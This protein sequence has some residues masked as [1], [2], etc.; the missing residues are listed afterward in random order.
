M[1]RLSVSALRDY[2]TCGH[3][4]YLKRIVG[5]D[6][7]N[8]HHAAAGSLVHDS[9]YMAYGRPV[10]LIDKGNFKKVRWEVTGEFHPEYALA[11]FDALWWGDPGRLGEHANVLTPYYE[12]LAQTTPPPENFVTGQKKALKASSQE[13][14]R[15]AWCEHYR[16][17]LEGGVAQPFDLPVKEIERELTYTLGEHEAVGYADIVLENPNTGGEIYVDLKSGYNKPNEQ[18]L[19]FDEQ[20]MSYYQTGPEDIWYYHLRSGE[21]IAVDENVPLQRM[22][23]EV[24]NQTAVAIDSGYFPKRFSKDCV[25]CPFRVE[26]IGI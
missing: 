12:M 11:M 18:E 26:C 1:T 6:A 10:E 23:A 24:A 17:M 4:Y 21:L 5:K 16:E 22:I 13:A 15:A 8:S 14:L 19:F 3:Y 7:Y 20:M 25:R 2:N 9:F